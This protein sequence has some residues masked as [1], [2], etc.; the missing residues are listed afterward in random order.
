[1]TKDEI[2]KIASNHSANR[3]F[4]KDEPVYA[5]MGNE[6]IIA[7]AKSIQAQC[8]SGEAEPDRTGFIYYKN[9]GCTAPSALHKD[10]ICWTKGE[11]VDISNLDEWLDNNMPSGT[12]IGDPKWWARKIRNVIAF[13]EP[14]QTAKIKELQEMLDEQR[15]T[16]KA[17]NTCIGGEC[18]LTTDNLSS[19]GQLENDV[20]KLQKQNYVM[21]EALIK[22]EQYMMLTYGRSISFIDTAL[23]TVGGEL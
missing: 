9:N 22:T 16:I 23:A 15:L 2:L 3:I 18:S 21:R 6:A 11:A 8:V 19:I 1:M 20:E 14:D 4:S 7:F 12:I 5:L 10:C 17:L 13:T